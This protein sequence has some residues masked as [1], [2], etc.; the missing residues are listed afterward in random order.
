[1][2]FI[3]LWP[4]TE[5]MLERI[6]HNSQHHQVRQRAH[7]ILLSHRGW[8]MNELLELFGISRRTLQYW[9]SRWK[10]DRLIGLYDRAGR[11]RKSKL[12]KHE[13]EQ[14]IEWIKAEPTKLSNVQN[15]INTKWGKSVSK[16]TLKRIAKNCQM[17]WRR[18][19]RG[20]AG[21]PLEWEY[22]L[23][24]E[25]LKELEELEKNGEID[26]RYLDQSGICLTPYIPYGWQEKGATIILRSSRSKRLNIVGLI[27]RNNQLEYE[28]Y[29]GSFTSQKLI[30]F[31]DKFS[32]KITR[33]TVVILD[34]SS[35]H[36]SNAVLAK[37]E[38]WKE[39]QLEIFWLPPYS[40][41]LNL[42]EIFWKFLKYE[43]IKLDAYENFSSLVNYVT[44][45]LDNV[46]KTY[47]INFA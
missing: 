15:K 7:C 17:T 28:L 8:T 22:D 13:Q 14:V 4:E 30:N 24:V 34:Q 1:M 40:P 26:L 38:E 19:K 10:Q 27:N 21:K 37:L 2:K 42:I 5:K 32:E 18:M 31:L 9:F 29:D 44:N 6:Y 36:T 47:A 39:K 23:K 45:V 33:K 35:V 41:Q 46:G 11:G 3:K 20:L 43:W 12:N 16:D 25:R